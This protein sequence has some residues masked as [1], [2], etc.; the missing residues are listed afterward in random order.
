MIS[1]QRSVIRY[2]QE[3][4]KTYPADSMRPLCHRGFAETTA[5]I[6][7][8]TVNDIY[9]ATSFILPGNIVPTNNLRL[10]SQIKYRHSRT[11]LYAG[12]YDAAGELL[13]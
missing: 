11:K 4:Y 13:F 9:A 6:S 5:G 7:S 2:L 1:R 10:S 12:E 3:L 8:R